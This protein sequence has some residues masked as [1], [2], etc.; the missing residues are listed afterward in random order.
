[1]KPKS[2]TEISKSTKA[3]YDRHAKS[4]SKMSKAALGREQLSFNQLVEWFLAQNGRWKTATIIAYRCALVAKARELYGA[5]RA[6][7]LAIDLRSGPTPHSLKGKTVSGRP[8]KRKDITAA[9]WKRFADAAK[10]TGEDWDSFIL[11]FLAFGLIVTSRP[12]ELGSMAI[13]ADTLWIQ[14]AK[15][16]SVRGLDQS[17]PVDVLVQI[18]SDQV[19]TPEG[20]KF[21]SFDLTSLDDADRRLIHW[22]Q[23]SLPDWVREKGG[24]KPFYDAL[25]ARCRVLSARAKVHPAISPASVR[26]LSI[27][28]VKAAR[29][30]RAAAA[31]AGH[32]T[33]KASTHSYKHASKKS[34]KVSKAHIMEP[35]A[36]AMLRVAAVEKA[37]HPRERTDKMKQDAEARHALAARPVSDDRVF[38]MPPMKQ[39]GTAASAPA[40][41]TT[42]GPKAPDRRQEMLD[43]L[44][45]A[46]P[47]SPRKNPLGRLPISEDAQPEAN[48]DTASDDALFPMLKPGRR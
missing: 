40:G 46:L 18:L 41:G 39:E 31:A 4:L 7:T 25:R 11:D 8:T 48:A 21:R 35:D 29:G 22:M 37:F 32:A 24:W 30:V 23:I 42:V 36:K 9:E 2:S 38:F 19:S 14:T 45:K 17:P 5:E 12:I 16:N 10:S 43:F 1:M 3:I 20:S 13:H 34:L 33:T 15:A 28:A 6:A 26:H 27:S 44:A 47:K